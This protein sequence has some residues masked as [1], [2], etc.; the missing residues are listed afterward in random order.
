MKCPP[1]SESSG[2]FTLTKRLTP[3]TGSGIKKPSARP[4]KPSKLA[5]AV[6]GES[7]QV[8]KKWQAFFDSARLAS[9]DNKTVRALLLGALEEEGCKKEAESDI[10]TDAGERSDKYD[11]KGLMAKIY[12][13]LHNV[14]T[15]QAS[16]YA[17]DEA[18]APRFILGEY[19]DIDL[20]LREA[21]V[22][23]VSAISKYL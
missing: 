7:P 3:P 12:K 20:F 15:A 5:Q 8:K 4:Q 11:V 1:R 16:R 2:S 21:S 10:R 17:S 9:T 19:R 14:A 6:E 13:D 23:V 18:S 22:G